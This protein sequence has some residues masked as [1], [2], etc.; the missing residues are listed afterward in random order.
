MGRSK[1]SK[2]LNSNLKRLQMTT[3]PAYAKTWRF[4]DPMKHVAFEGEFVRLEP[5]TLLEKFRD[6][7]LDGLTVRSGIHS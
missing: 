7:V 4:G 1:L 3:Q 2:L 6:K 5:L